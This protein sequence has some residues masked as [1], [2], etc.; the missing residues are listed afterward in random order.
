MGAVWHPTLFDIHNPASG[1]QTEKHSQP[2]TPYD[3]PY[4]SL[5]PKEIGGL[6]LSGRNVSGT[7]RAHASYRVMGE[8]LA[9]G[10]TAGTAAALSAKEG[11]LPG[12]WTNTRRMRLRR[13]TRT[14][15]CGRI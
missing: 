9:T 11:S 3:I 12:R 1:G 4:R 7:H 13:P 6:L 15:F 14:A 5:V 8:A 2:A 10:Q